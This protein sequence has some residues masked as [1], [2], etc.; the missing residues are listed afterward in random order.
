M[1][2]SKADSSQTSAKLEGEQEHSNE[3][4]GHIFL[5][6]G[7]RIAIMFAVVVFKASRLG[8]GE[9]APLVKRLP[10]SH[11]GLSSH[12]DTHMHTNRTNTLEQI[13]NR[14]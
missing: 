3:Q 9:K 7:Q 12:P 13:H 14:R 10:C 5:P 6:S 1:G 11:E 4:K 8:A 2:R